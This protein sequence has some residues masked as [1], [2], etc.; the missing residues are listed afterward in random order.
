M[1]T[2]YTC[3]RCKACALSMIDL[4]KLIDDMIRENPDATIR[5][6]LEL[7]AELTAISNA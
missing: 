4:A 3:R 1:V 7:V 5:D 2:I 6:Y